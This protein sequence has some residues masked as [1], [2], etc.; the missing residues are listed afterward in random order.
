[1]QNLKATFADILL[2]HFWMAK[3]KNLMKTIGEIWVEY[4]T[5]W[6]ELIQCMATVSFGWIQWWGV[7]EEVGVS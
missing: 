6:S 5:I 2:P 4:K 7:E 1:M 3:M